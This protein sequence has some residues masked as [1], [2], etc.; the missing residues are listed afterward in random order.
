VAVIIFD[1]VKTNKGPLAEATFFLINK[2]VELSLSF[3]FD[4]D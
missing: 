1:Q 4:E 3:D 2:P